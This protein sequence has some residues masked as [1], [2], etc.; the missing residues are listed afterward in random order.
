MPGRDQA[1]VPGCLSRESN[2]AGGRRGRRPVQGDLTPTAVVIG[3]EGFVRHRDT[4]AEPSR[5][6]TPRRVVCDV[7]EAEL[8]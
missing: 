6:E 2:P 8:S 3:P 1:C 4:S 7:L 5:E